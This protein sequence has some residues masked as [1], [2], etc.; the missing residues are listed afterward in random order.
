MQ[1][2]DVSM[3]HALQDLHFSLGLERQ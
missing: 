3:R 1:L 2:D